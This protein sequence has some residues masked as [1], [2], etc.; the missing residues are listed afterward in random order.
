MRCIGCVF[1]LTIALFSQELANRPSSSGDPQGTFYLNGLAY[2]FMASANYTV[3]VAAAPIL[4]GKYL[5]VKVRVVNTSGRSIIVRPETLTVQDATAERNLEAIPAGDLAN[6]LRHQL[7]I[8][9]IM[10][11]A[12]VGA[13]GSNARPP[14]EDQRWIDL[15][16]ALH[17]EVASPAT[18][19]VDSPVLAYA[20]TRPRLRLRS[21]PEIVECDLACQ[22][23]WRESK[24]PEELLELQRSSDPEHIED[25]VLLANT[26]PPQS[27]AAGLLYFPMPKTWNTA[28]SKKKGRKMFAVTVHVQVAEERFTFAFPVE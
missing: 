15:M 16:H 24:A 4:R 9:K 22:L 2:E 7:K 13:P 17:R 28:P 8:A 26:V 21:E 25:A 1:L 18:G 19:N 11:Q 10:E 6:K 27:D 20:D 12:T 5:G 23:R 14:D 3:V